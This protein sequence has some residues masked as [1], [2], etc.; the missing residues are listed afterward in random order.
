MERGS[1][2]M[3]ESRGCPGM[4]SHTKANPQ[5]AKGGIRRRKA[6]RQQTKTKR[7]ALPSSERV[8]QRPEGWD[9][10]SSRDLHSGTEKRGSGGVD[11]DLSAWCGGGLVPGGEQ[12]RGNPTCGKTKKGG[13]QFLF[14]TP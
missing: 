2:M 11:G 7:T 9:R 12:R 4:G 13:D 3:S 5:T 1:A 8:C 10:T 6:N 14:K